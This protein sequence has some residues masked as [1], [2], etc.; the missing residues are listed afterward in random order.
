MTKT[1]LGIIGGSGLYGIDGLQDSIWQSMTTPRGAPSD[2]ILTGRLDGLPLAFLPRHGR[3]HVHAPDTIPYRANIDALKQLGVTDVLSISACGSFRDEMAPGHFVLV[4]QYL[5]R[6][7]GRAPSFFGTGCVAHVSLA[8]P[9]C[10]R[11]T[12][13]VATACTKAEIK[14]HRGG[15]YLAME[16]PQFSSL[17]ES[18]LYRD[19]L[20]CDVIGMTAMP[21][22]RLAREAE[23]CYLTVAMITDYDSWHPDHGAVSITDIIAT[24]HSNAG[25]ARALIRALPSALNTSRDPCSDGCDRALDHAIL[26]APAH[27]DPALVTKLGTI[28]G[29]IL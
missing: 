6:T 22:A 9:A 20:G 12:D 10:D 21:E 17:A 5:D 11:L 1:Y 28:A 18:R 19:T 3:G 13:S 24:A 27:R 25:Q 26:T 4:D 14:A 7:K 23:L 8:H 29:R 2:Q 15:T 16:G